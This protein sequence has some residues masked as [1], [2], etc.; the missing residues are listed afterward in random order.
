MFMAGA[1]VT[2]IVWSS[3]RT[4]AGQGIVAGRAMPHVIAPRPNPPATSPPATNPPVTGAA[5]LLPFPYYTFRPHMRI[6]PGLWIGFPVVFPPLVHERYGP[7]PLLPSRML[8]LPGA[9]STI[10]EPSSRQVL[11]GGVIEITP[12]T[13]QVFVDDSYIGTVAEFT[14]S[15]L[16]LTLTPGRHRIEIRATD[17]QSIAFDADIAAGKIIPYQGALPE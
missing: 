1:A 3:P 7:D 16:P 13:A 8:L 17:Y 6:A 12:V 10:A 9:G 15:T 2:L 5:P 11:P 14:P 4:V